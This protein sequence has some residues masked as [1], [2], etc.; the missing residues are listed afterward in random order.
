M[1]FVFKIAGQAGAGVM[2]TGRMMV[3]C[4]TR[5]GYNV[6][7]Y[8]EYPSLVRGG[9]NTVQV[10]VSDAQINSP[11]REC[12]LVIALNKD[13]IFYH[14]ESMAQGGMIIY[15]QL[16]DTGRFKLRPDVRMH[17][18]PLS[19]LTLDVGG[20]EQMKNTAAL[21]AALAAV[22][23]PFEML[24]T[25]IR[26]E[27]ARKGEE[28][29]KVNISA[30]KA[31]YDF[32]KTNG[33]S[34]G[35]Q[36]KPVHPERR[37][38][39]T[40]NEAIALGAVRG[41]MKFYAAYPMT[42]ASSILHYLIDKERQFGIIAKQTEDEIAAINYA[43]GAAFAGARSMVGTS[44]GGFALMVEALG[45]AA[46][47]ETPLVVALV[48]RNGPSTGLPTWTEQGDLRFAL[49]ASQGDFPRVILAPG[50]VQEAFFLTAKA[51]NLSEKYQ[52][53]VLVLSDKFLSETVFSTERFD[54]SKVIIERGKLVKGPLPALA[55]M[56]RWKRYAITEDGVSER[57]LPGTPNGMHVATSYEHDETGFS[58]ESFVMRAKQ[59]DKR[60]S[61]MKKLLKE[62]EP[63]DVFGEKENAEVTLLTWGSMKLPALDALA[64]LAKKGVK[65]RLVSFT[66]V[67]PL[68]PRHVKKA[69]RNS[70]ATIMVENNSTAQFA[71]M[72]REY[73]GVKV[74]FHMLKYDGRQFFAEQIAEETL[75]LRESGYKGGQRV[76]V[77]EK[78]D[79][80]YYNPQRHGL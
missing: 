44:G 26:E 68:N 22:D 1:D 43:I 37:P 63:P 74:D 20:T 17:A 51:H 56:A 46:M 53:P 57:A 50:D 38:I 72:L 59:V 76:E 48:Q 8:P 71:G 9:H 16:I 60:A 42:P 3:K 52:I 6:I 13:A 33:I 80:E 10:R 21:G 55:P 35:S 75:K 41:G 27:L 36:I 32:V 65:A 14:M 73:A 12:D 47:S 4:F 77:V 70:G 78:E 66:H 5:G 61:K 40:G 34:F 39:I 18:L 64:L 29:I 23:Y 69:L 54:Q 24:E 7:G 67:Y 30:A 11:R 15:D 28:V 79:M 2:I 31:G 49:H 45:L 58:S 62:M 25:L 19:K